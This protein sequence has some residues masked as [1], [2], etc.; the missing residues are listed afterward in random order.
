MKKY[1]TKAEKSEKEDKKDKKT[2]GKPNAKGESAA[3]SQKK[4]RIRAIGNG[5]MMMVMMMRFRFKR[6]LRKPRRLSRMLGLD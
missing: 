2:K 5:N 1:W 6:G 3:P 4:E